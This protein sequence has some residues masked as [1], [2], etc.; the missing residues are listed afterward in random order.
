MNFQVIFLLDQS[1]AVAN[2][3]VNIH[4][5]SAPSLNFRG[6]LDAFFKQCTVSRT[7]LNTVEIYSKTILNFIKI[8]EKLL[9]SSHRRRRIYTEEQAK[10]VP[11]DWG[12]YL[13]ARQYSLLAKR[14][15]WR[16]VFGRTSLWEG[17]GLVWCEL[18]DHPFFRCIHS[19][20]CSFFYSSISSNH[21][22]AKSVVRQGIEAI[23]PPKLQ[24]R[25]FPS[26]LYKV[27]FNRLNMH[28][29]EVRIKKLQVFLKR[30]IR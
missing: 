22:G 15:I 30:T 24:Q 25:P 6:I 12:T 17:G 10:V 5:A 23:H 21:P 7:L 26:L 1:I 11:A 13:N 9:S 14:L 3:V 2:I 18:E 4:I 29:Q 8:F 27:F 19:A 16:N 28:H 20:K